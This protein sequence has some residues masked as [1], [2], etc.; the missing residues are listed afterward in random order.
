MK[1]CIA[2]LQPSTGNVEKNIQLHEKLIDAAASLS[3]DLIVFPEL[4]LTGYEPTLAKELATTADDARFDFFEQVSNKRK[5]TIGV[6]MPIT[7]GAGINIA[8]LCFVPGKGRQLYI[9]K[10]LHADE[11]PFFVSGQNPDTPILNHLSIA[12]AICY[13]ISIP[14]HAEDAFKKG[15]RI[16]LASVAK[17]VKG[18]ESACARLADIARTYSMVVLMANCTGEADGV[19]CAGRSS[20]WNSDG[21]LIGQLGD[22]SEGLLILDTETLDVKEH[23]TG[24]TSIHYN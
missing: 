22:T 7:T 12:L 3:A 10:Y 18:I 20:I 15:G 23:V 19:V 13:E 2:Q 1:I 4:S 21:N 11:E 14:A 5:I 16:Y 17:S 6:G 9:K 8:M 24:S